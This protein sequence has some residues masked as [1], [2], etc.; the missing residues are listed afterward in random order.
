MGDGVSHSVHKGHRRPLWAGGASSG[1]K[2]WAG[3]C[4]AGPPPGQWGNP[5]WPKGWSGGCM[6]FDLHLL[7]GHPCTTFSFGS[8]L[9]SVCL[10]GF[11]FFYIEHLI[12]WLYGKILWLHIC[13][14]FLIIFKKINEK[15]ITCSQVSLPMFF[16]TY[17]F[18]NNI[19]SVVSINSDQ[20]KI[21]NELALMLIKIQC[22]THFVSL[23]CTFKY[24][25]LLNMSKKNF[26][27]P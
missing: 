14:I 4:H 10:F 22:T 17:M 11:L 3:T 1:P 13:I 7:Q 27:V 6:T 5:G 15:L 8:T 23:I 18:K 2:E 24:Y 19:N 26:L 9:L 16:H 20:L 25:E 12:P 21:I